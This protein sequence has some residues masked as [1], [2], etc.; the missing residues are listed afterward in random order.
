MSATLIGIS[1]TVNDDLN[2]KKSIFLSQANTVQASIGSNI[3]TKI[4]TFITNVLSAPYQYFLLV[5]IAYAFWI[6]NEMNNGS[7]GPI[8]LL[9]YTALYIVLAI[10]LFP[11]VIIGVV[12]WNIVLLFFGNNNSSPD[13]L[14]LKSTTWTNEFAKPIQDMNDFIVSY[15]ENRIPMSKDDWACRM[16][17]FSCEMNLN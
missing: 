7:T 1:A 13:V 2:Q 10:V 15:Q 9:L 6:T 17:A 16:D 14:D 11:V 12:V 4:N 3:I 5:V 8:K